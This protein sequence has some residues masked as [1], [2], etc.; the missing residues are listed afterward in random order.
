[1]RKKYHSAKNTAKG[2]QHLLKSIFG[3]TLTLFASSSMDAAETVA[4]ADPTWGLDPVT[5][6]LLKS[7]ICC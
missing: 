1:M 5:G 2:R 6:T 3:L 7:G 4:P